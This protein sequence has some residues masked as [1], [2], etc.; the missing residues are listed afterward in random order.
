[1]KETTFSN[2]L[3]L[4][5]GIDALMIARRVCDLS[6]KLFPHGGYRGHRT[7]AAWT[8]EQEVYLWAAFFLAGTG[9]I[10]MARRD[11]RPLFYWNLC[12]V[13][14]LTVAYPPLI[15]GIEHALFFAASLVAAVSIYFSRRQS[16]AA[17]SSN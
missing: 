17:S 8:G 9:G 6:S 5:V 16:K 7:L 2:W 11:T 12:C 1:M 3:F 10:V 4:A 15:G 13:A 14:T